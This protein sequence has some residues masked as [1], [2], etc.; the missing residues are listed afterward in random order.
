[1]DPATLVTQALAAGT[2]AGLTTTASAAVCDA[3]RALRQACLERLPERYRA[4]Y[5]DGS[6]DISPART[7]ELA[8]HLIA[9][10][11]LDAHVVRLAQHVMSLADPAG[12][13]SGSCQVDLRAAQ[14]VQIGDHN[15]QHNTFG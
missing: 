3:Y 8:H 4:L 5:A 15:V 7:P 9:A 14:G 12:T 6:T 2:G 1:M 10:G 11:G 13:R